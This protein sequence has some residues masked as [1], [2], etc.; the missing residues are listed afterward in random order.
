[1]NAAGSITKRKLSSGKLSW[2]FSFFAGRDEEGKRIQV[3]RSGFSTRKAA[4]TALAA[5]VERHQQGLA[6]VRDGRSFGDFLRGW[7][8]NHAARR[9]SPRTLEAYRQSADYILR[10]LEDVPLARVTPRLLQETVYSLSESGGR[11]RKGNTRKLAPKTVRHA[12]FVVHGAYETAFRLGEVDVNP[13]ARVELPKLEAKDPNI[14]S[15]DDVAKLLAIAEGTDLYAL[16]VLALGSGCR[17]GELLALRWADIDFES[18][19]MR[20]SA[21]LEQTREGLRVKSTKSGKPRRVVLPVSTLR[22][23]GEHR[24][25][26]AAAQMKAR[27]LHGANFEDLGLVFA[28]HDGR[29][30]RPDRVS[31]AFCEMARK[32]GLKIGLHLLRHQSASELLSAGVPLPAVSQRLGHASPSI[33]SAIYA[34]ALSED[35]Q[36]AAQRWEAQFGS[37]FDAPKSKC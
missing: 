4:A 27:A 26:Q 15:R 19:T 5:A 29:H 14:M 23:L 8:D 34:H 20:V 25:R 12:A 30:L 18:S 3:T 33:T 16:T 35:E 11:D 24:E 10:S 37:M 32:V 22:I 7:L 31:S 13:M 36:L 2:G 1:M 17:R 28:N 9:V 21:S 6:V